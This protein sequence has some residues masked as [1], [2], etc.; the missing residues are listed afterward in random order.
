MGI[1]G[2]WRSIQH[3]GAYMNESLQLH[4]FSAL[5]SQVAWISSARVVMMQPF[6][7]Q[8]WGCLFGRPAWWLESLCHEGLSKPSYSSV[9]HWLCYSPALVIGKTVFWIIEKYLVW[10][11]DFFELYN[12]K[13]AKALAYTKICQSPVRLHSIDYVC[14]QVEGTALDQRART[15]VVSPVFP[16]ENDLIGAQ[17]TAVLDLFAGQQSVSKG[18][19]PKLNYWAMGLV[20]WNG[21]W[22]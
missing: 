8:S 14:Q 12:R 3:A 20:Q 15:L 18:F 19:S 6:W 7:H 11:L 22:L 13:H 1:G 16:Q 9:C 17:D 5:N 2:T 21:Q 4:K 10:I